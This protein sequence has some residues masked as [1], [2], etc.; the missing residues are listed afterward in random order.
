MTIEKLKAE[1]DAAVEEEIAARR[2]LYQ[3]EEACRE[4]VKAYNAARLEAASIV[5][6][7]TIVRI[8]RPYRD[9]PTFARVVRPSEARFDYVV[10]QEIKKDGTVWAGRRPFSARISDTYRKGV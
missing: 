2:D 7:E 4:K 8:Q 10:V 6:G 5:T 9:K 3:K 1:A